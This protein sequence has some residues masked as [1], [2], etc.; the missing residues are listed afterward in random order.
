MIPV[1][2]LVGRPNVGKSTIFNALTGCR[3]ALVADMPGVTRDRQYGKGNWADHPFVVIDTGGLEAKA[4]QPIQQATQ[5][6][7]WLAIEEA[8]VVL[9]VVDAKQGVI[10][11]DQNIARSLR[12]HNKHCILVVNKIDAAPEEYLTAEF[13]RLGFS[14]VCYVSAAH[15]RGIENILESSFD[16][17]PN[18]PVCDTA[19]LEVDDSE[20]GVGDDDTL[21]EDSALVEDEE[22]PLG[23]IKVALIGQ[24]NAGKSTL[25]NRMLGEERV[26]VS[27]IPGTTR[28]SIS[29][30]FE[31]MGQQYTLIDTAG[32]RK[33]QSVEEGVE[34][35]S[36]VKSLQS[37][38]QAHVVLFLIDAVLGFTM[39]DLHLLDFVIES[40]RSLVIVINK[41]DNLP[42]DQKKTVQHDL[43]HRLRFASFARQRTI[44]AR[45]GSGVGV[46]WADIIEAYKAAMR[47][48]P[49][50]LLTELLNR[51]VA[52]NPPP[53]VRGR[54]IKLRYAHC[55]GHM[56][57]KIVLHG[58]QTESLPNTYIRYLHNQFRAGLKLVGTPLQIRCRT[59]DNPFASLAKRH[60]KQ[61]AQVNNTRRGRGV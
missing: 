38:D 40:G 46:L 2:A 26:I 34:H 29:V 48:L 59:S 42:E 5:D 49:T 24:P 32:I 31:R 61:K 27:E 21:L 39:Q 60:R 45:H 6:Q 15:T 44:S 25:M 35:F 36:V 58:N 56:P 50:S 43:E 13:S 20:Q 53:L 37:I 17:L 23:V 12:K 14:D 47:P 19:D 3:G 30:D 10:A 22:K 51:A 28:D 33:K 4:N 11:E 52:H 18:A 54:R 16:R 8:D 57:P 41:W 7:S 1:F 9:F 55:G